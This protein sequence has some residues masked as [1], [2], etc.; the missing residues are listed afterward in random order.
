MR[1]LLHKQRPKPKLSLQTI[2]VNYTKPTRITKL[3]AIIKPRIK[4]APKSQTLE[5][6]LRNTRS[7][8]NITNSKR[9]HKN[10]LNETIQLLKNVNTCEK[11]VLQSSYL[12]RSQIRRGRSVIDSRSQDE[13]ESTHGSDYLSS[14]FQKQLRKKLNL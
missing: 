14:V 11:H 10:W 9:I 6:E 8:F 2:T 13:V 5:L 7:V 12:S 3:P 4:P 1:S